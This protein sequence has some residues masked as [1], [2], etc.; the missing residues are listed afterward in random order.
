MPQLRQDRFTKEWVFVATE[1]V[2]HP[3]DLVVKRTKKRL[4]AFD[5]HCPFCPGNEDQ[6]PPE[7]LRVPSPSKCGWTVRVVPSKFHGLR[8][9]ANKGRTASGRRSFEGFGIHEVI[10]ETPDH[11]LTTALLPEAQVASVLRASKMRYDELSLDP[12]IAHA[13]LFKRHGLEA[14]AVLEH[15]H[16]HFIATP[17][18]SAHVSNRLREARR[19]YD[20][21]RECIYCTVLQEELHA[22]TRIVMASE[23]FVALEP[24]ASPTPFCTHIY[25]RRH[26]ANFGEI[27]S[28]EM[29][30]LARI[31]RG[32]LAKLYFGLED[33]NFTYTIR[34]GRCRTA[35]R[36][37]TTGT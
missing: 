28:D 24:F 13:T 6:T 29:G 35:A 16:C 34:R 19:H 12:G 4:P 15:S 32:V 20:E 21:F 14:G 10:V 1:Y 11:S 33:P 22:Q 18:V 27:S 9:D 3:Q 36:A 25:P 17:E 5:P 2:K 37:T 7:V 30:D 8:P 23:H 26:M 31:L